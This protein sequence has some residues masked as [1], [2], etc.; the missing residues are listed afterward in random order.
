MCGTPECGV[1]SDWSKPTGTAL[2]CDL[3]PMN[4]RVCD[5]TYG[6][7]NESDVF[8]MDSAEES[9]PADC[10]SWGAW[11]DWNA[12]S[13]SCTKQGYKERTRTCDMK[14]SGLACVGKNTERQACTGTCGEWA[15]GDTPC[16]TNTCLNVDEGEKDIVKRT[17]NGSNGCKND[18]GNP[19]GYGHN[20]MCGTPECGVWSDWSNPT[21]TELECY[22]KPTKTRKCEGPE[23]CINNN[24]EFFNFDTVESVDV[25]CYSWDKWSPWSACDATSCTE[26][27]YKE[28]TRTCSKGVCK[29][30]AE[31]TEQCNLPCDGKWVWDPKVCEDKQTSKTTKKECVAEDGRACE[32]N[33]LT[34]WRGQS[35]SV[36]VPECGKWYMIGSCTKSKSCLKDW[37]FDVQITSICLGEICKHANLFYDKYD[38]I[39]ESCGIP[40]CKDSEDDIDWS[41]PW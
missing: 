41:V 26:Q 19:V 13:A 39:K 34:Y 10:F 32:H 29:G 23:R 37:E 33:G 12:C 22:L 40:K 14:N 18:D 21:D 5:G 38:S 27:G 1:W 3:K 15:T 30:L 6:C 31:E 36:D 4:T 25:N 2:E 9:I 11:S 16:P 35:R 8:F 17:C 24:G 28:R 20:E 7:K